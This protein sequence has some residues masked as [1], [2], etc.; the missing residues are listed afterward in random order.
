MRECIT[1]EFGLGTLIEANNLFLI[2]GD[3][4]FGNKRHT[5]AFPNGFMEI[6]WRISS[7]LTP[8]F[9]AF[10]AQYFALS[11]TFLRLA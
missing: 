4:P 6:S 1:L 8:A 5:K 3:L 11:L 2:T 10:D 7:I 9:K